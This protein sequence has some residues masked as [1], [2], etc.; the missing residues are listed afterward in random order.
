MHIVFL[1]TGV[2]E[3]VSRSCVGRTKYKEIFKLFIRDSKCL[4]KNN[5]RTCTDTR[6]NLINIRTLCKREPCI[7][8]QRQYSSEILKY[9]H[10]KLCLYSAMH[11]WQETPQS[12]STTS[13]FPTHSCLILR[14]QH[15]KKDSV[16]PHIWVLLDTTLNQQE[17]PTE[18]FG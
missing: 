4:T 6:Q 14:K 8:H 18:C 11:Q 3:K 5:S 9:W 1:A 15:R 2:S 10:W 12:L 17:N 13:P 16:I 7:K